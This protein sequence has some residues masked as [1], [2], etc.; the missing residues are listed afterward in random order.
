MTTSA[1]TG[2][3][4]VVDD[5]DYA[6]VPLVSALGP[7]VDWCPN[8]GQL[9]RRID[10]GETWRAAFIDFFLGIGE[11]CGLN[12]MMLL[13][14][15]TPDIRLV[16]FTTFG[17]GGGRTLFAAAANHWYNAVFVNKGNLDP[18]IV[19]RAADPTDNP[20]DSRLRQ[21]LRHAHLVDALFVEPSW[22][23]IWQAWPRFDGS[24]A[25]IVT[26]LGPTYTPAVVRGFAQRAITAVER[27]EA[28]FAASDPVSKPARGNRAQAAPLARFAAENRVFFSAPDLGHVLS[29]VNPGGHRH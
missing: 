25:A 28:A 27:F 23:P 18:S 15:A 3:V 22:L 11:P 10:N 12:A 26:A 20:T 7:V 9:K 2:R 29:D 13:R 6:Q 14:R 1:V 17:D 21:Q 24:Q 5:Q 8:I 16:S 19:R 4:L